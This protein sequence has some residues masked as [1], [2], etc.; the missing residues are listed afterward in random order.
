[1]V[2][3]A[4]FALLGLGWTLIAWVGLMVWWGDPFTSLYT[5]HEQ[6]AMSRELDAL[7]TRWATAPV[8]RSIEQHRSASSEQR[9]AAL[10]RTRAVAFQHSIRDGEPM[11]RIVIPRL[12]VNMVVIQGT[13]ESDL[14]H[15]PGHYDAASGT[16]TTVPGMGGV[17][18]I[19]GH[20]TTYLH[21]FRHI[22][23]LRAGDNVYLEMP[24][25]TF[26][27][28]MF[29]HKIVS[30]N[31][32]TI[33]RHRSFEQLVLTACHPLYSATHRWVVFARLRGEMPS[34]LPALTTS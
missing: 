28:T 7:D 14:R 21:P 18:G 34:T 25:G 30:S 5:R 13:S 2:R 9:L 31:D 17:V 4:G 11:G 26:R 6:H 10:L 20:R 23:D 22:D 33:L 15:A 24:Y 32:W 27:Y 8:A 16:N 1:V 12:H 29:A 19:A 3:T